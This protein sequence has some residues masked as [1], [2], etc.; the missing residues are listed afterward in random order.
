MNKEQQCMMSKKEVKLLR[1]IFLIKLSYCRFPEIPRGYCVCLLLSPC[2]TDSLCVSNLLAPFR[3]VVPQRRCSLLRDEYG[4]SRLGRD[5]AHF[6]RW[7]RE[8]CITFAHRTVQ[9]PPV[10]NAAALQNAVFSPTCQFINC[11]P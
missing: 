8:L 1:D 11:L 3:T 10:E 2:R 6:W 5:H 7:K 4:S 9:Q